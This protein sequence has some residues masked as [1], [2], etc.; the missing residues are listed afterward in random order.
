[1]NVKQDTCQCCVCLCPLTC[2]KCFL[3]SVRVLTYQPSTVRMS[4]VQGLDPSYLTST[5]ADYAVPFHPSTLATIP[6]D[7]QSESAAH[8]GSQHYHSAVGRKIITFLS[9]TFRSG[10]VFLNS[11]RSSGMF[12]TAL[13][14]VKQLCCV[15]ICPPFNIQS[16]T[17]LPCFSVS[18]T[19][20]SLSH[21]LEVQ[22]G[23]PVH[24]WNTEL[25][26]SSFQTC[27][28][29]HVYRMSHF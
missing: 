8:T 28:P 23:N 17:K 29:Q 19:E 27:N 24:N 22:F 25:D 1:M 7:M 13:F 10:I 2:V 3:C 26:V 16:I 9:L 15:C 20:F 14:S 6:T 11:S 12:V 21:I 4:N 18:N 5:L